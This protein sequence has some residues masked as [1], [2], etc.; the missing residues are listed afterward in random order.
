[1]SEPSW[2]DLY[3]NWR[4]ALE[5]TAGKNPRQPGHWFSIWRMIIG[6]EWYQQQLRACVGSTIRASRLPPDL[7]HD[8]EQEVIL[9]LAG[10]L[11]RRR[12][13][14]MDLE[15]AKQKFPGFMQSVIRNDCLHITRKLRRQFLR[16]F[17]LL[18]APCVEDRTAERCSRVELTLE[19]EELN[20]P[21]RTI[22]LLT[23]KGMTLKE[24]SQKI[25]MDYS[26]VCREFHHGQQRLEKIL[27]NP[28]FS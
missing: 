17:P 21:Q 2:R 10:K 27:D 4:N 28:H 23:V 8:L 6:H 25:Q 26:K 3:L 24:I 22:L 20:D 11:A 14:G 9:L 16:S 18:A 1:M 15:L 5:E 19:I 7:A 12:D 13:L